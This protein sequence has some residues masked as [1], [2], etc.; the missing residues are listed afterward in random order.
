MQ[1]RRLSIYHVRA[2]IQNQ[3]GALSSTTGDGGHSQ[4]ERGENMTRERNTRPVAGTT[5]R[6]EAETAAGQ[7]AISMSNCTTGGA[8]RQLSVSD[9]L[10]KGKENAQ[11]MRELRQ[12]LNGDSRS[13]RLQ[14]EHER[15][16]GCPIVSDCQHGY[17]LA[18]TRAEIE[19]FVRSM[20]ARAFE[21][22]WTAALVQMAEVGNDG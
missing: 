17:W 18:E 9:V 12:I 6:A 1:K 8:G 10:C 11:T 22:Q 2:R 7:A 14:I 15:R 5:R 21:I 13:I 4:F 16:G 20:K 19:N 3:Y